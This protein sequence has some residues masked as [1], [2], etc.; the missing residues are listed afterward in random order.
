MHWT[1]QM[2][3]TNNGNFIDRGPEKQ[4][5]NPIFIVSVPL[6]RIVLLQHSLSLYLSISS[7]CFTRLSF[8]SLASLLS[9]IVPVCTWSWLVILAKYK[10]NNNENNQVFTQLRHEIVW[11]DHNKKSKTKN[12]KN[13]AY[14]N[15]QAFYSVKIWY[16]AYIKRQ[17][18]TTIP[19][20]ATIYSEVYFNLIYLVT[21]ILNCVSFF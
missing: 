16:T 10:N 12:A 9:I 5:N 1:Q 11:P 14:R 21:Q 13:T 20:N 15:T 7:L 4:R 6:N 17:R 18:H 2:Q 19:T 3:W 8:L